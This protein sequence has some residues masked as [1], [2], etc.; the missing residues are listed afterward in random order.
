ML[1]VCVPIVET[2]VE[3]ARRSIE[4]V[5]R[6][7]DLIEL[8]IDY[9]EKPRIKPLLLGNDVPFIV[10]NRRREEGGRYGS[11]EASRLCLLEEAI[12]LGVDFIDVEWST[13]RSLL[14]RLFKRKEGTRI[15]LSFHDFRGTPS[16]SKLE[17]IRRQ[18]LE[19]GADVT[20]IVT[21]S[22][23][24][25]D[26]LK[27]LSLIPRAREKGQPIV[28]FCMGEKGR[29][30]RLFAPVMGAAWTYG[31]MEKDRTSAPGQLTI[32]EMK[33]IWEKM[34]QSAA[35]KPR[36]VDQWG[37]NRTEPFR[38]RPYAQCAR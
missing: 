27:T 28:A 20:K 6:L 21:L 32:S 33:E 22:H 36:I 3:K 8:R 18:M 16:R 5:Q 1:K 30:S 15:I 10:T 34:A 37:D 25:E 17:S 26:N 14:Q 13:R 38:R 12:D 29:M 35:S 4:K 19:Y 9:L 23:T 11:D 7:A 31:C 24:Y 2:T